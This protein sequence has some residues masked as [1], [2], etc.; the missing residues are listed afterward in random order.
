MSHLQTASSNFR[1]SGRAGSAVPHSPSVAARRSPKRYAALGAA[2]HSS[3]DGHY[4][5]KGKFACLPTDEP[6][7]TRFHKKDGKFDSIQF[8]L[9]SRSTG[10]GADDRPYFMLASP[11]PADD[12]DPSGSCAGLSVN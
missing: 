2:W 6:E 11:S 1:W 5:P 4:R 3:R 12:R 10:P 9:T 8:R 7:V